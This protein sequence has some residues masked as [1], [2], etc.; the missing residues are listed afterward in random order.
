MGRRVAVPFP[1][2]RIVSLVPSQTELLF[3]LG[4]GE[5]VVGVTK[6]CI[7]P[8]EARTKAT[9]I[10]GTK[11]FDFEKIAALKPD[12]IIGNKEENYQ[13]GIEQLAADY[14]VWLSDISNLSEALDMIRRVGFIAGA[15]EKAAA[16]AAEIEVSFA[17]LKA[18]TADA[19]VSAAYFIWRKPYMV[20]AT[21]TFIDDLLLRAGFRNAFAGQTRY[22]EISAE[23]LA[24]AAPQRIMLS[25]EPYPFGEKHVA[26][27]QAIC[28]AAKIEIVDGE[29]FSWYGSRLR[30]S[31]AYFSHLH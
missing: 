12:L 11:N 5:K 27:F 19:L 14:P 2:Q 18:P 31:A 21:G 6:F 16:L 9:V 22:P 28:P 17:A 8:A 10:G 13:A 29:L 4:L 3:D 7:H 23:Q 24:A 25:S 15:R 20:A 26:E 30:K 1:P